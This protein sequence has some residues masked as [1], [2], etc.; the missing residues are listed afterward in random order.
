MRTPRWRHRGAVGTAARGRPGTHVRVSGGHSRCHET[1]TYVRDPAH[2]ELPGDRRSSSSAPGCGPRSGAARSTPAGGI[3]ESKKK[4][5]LRDHAPPQPYSHSV[6]GA[7]TWHAGGAHAQ[8]PRAGLWLRRAGAVWPAAAPPASGRSPAGIP[9]PGS[10]AGSNSPAGTCTRSPCA[11]RCARE[12]VALWQ[13]GG[14]LVYRG[15]SPRER[16]LPRDS[17]GRTHYSS[18]RA[19]I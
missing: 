15:G 18:P 17:P 5:L 10:T 1:A 11:G 8:P 3:R 14:T 12:A 9:G 2:C 19:L 6:F 7:R 16:L 13:S 4:I